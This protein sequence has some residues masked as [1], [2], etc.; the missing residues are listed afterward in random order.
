VP[1]E[2]LVVDKLCSG[3]RPSVLAAG[4]ML[5]QA[6]RKT[7]VA[8]VTTNALG[9]VILMSPSSVSLL[10]QPLVQDEDLDQLEDDEAIALMVSEGRSEATIL[11][12]MRRRRS[13]GVG[14]D[15]VE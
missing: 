9:H 13:R 11:D 1:D 2:V 12:Y 4:M 3:D 15:H 14:G 8:V 7:K 10:A 6:L 5:A